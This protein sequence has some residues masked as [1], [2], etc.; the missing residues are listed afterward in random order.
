MRCLRPEIA[1]DNDDGHETFRK[2][3]DLKVSGAEYNSKHASWYLGELARIILDQRNFY[4]DSVLP[5][6]KL[7]LI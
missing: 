6:Q 5:R 7:C 3:Q 1:F 4:E 2:M